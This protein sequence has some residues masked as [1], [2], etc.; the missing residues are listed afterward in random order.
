MLVLAVLCIE[1]SSA[2]SGGRNVG[3]RH[4][5]RLASLCLLCST[6]SGGGSSSGSVDSVVE[7]GSSVGGIVV[8]PPSNAGMS[9][10]YLSLRSSDR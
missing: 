1:C 3:I 8:C 4:R 7:G 9:C 2:G 5:T 10:L 6:G